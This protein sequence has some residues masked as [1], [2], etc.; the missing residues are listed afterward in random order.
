MKTEE[1]QKL[2]GVLIELQLDCAPIKLSIGGVDE[3]GHV[4]EDTIY[5]DECPPIVIEELVKKGYTLHLINGKLEVSDL[6]RF[7]K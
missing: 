7:K 4:E 6:R 5:L 1:K 2:F 3:S